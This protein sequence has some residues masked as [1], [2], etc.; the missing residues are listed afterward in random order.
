MTCPT[1]FDHRG[2]VSES[3][4]RLRTRLSGAKVD[5]PEFS[6]YF[7]RYL[8]SYLP[9]LDIMLFRYADIV[10]AALSTHA[11]IR[12]CT[13][14]DFGG[15]TGLL[16]LLA[17]ESGVGRVF[18][19]DIFEG[20]CREARL[21]A[22]QLGLEAD[23]YVCGEIAAIHAELDR[24][25]RGAVALASYDVIEHVYRLTEALA[26]FARLPAENLS[27]FL[28]S[29]ANAANLM[30]RAKLVRHHNLL[31]SHT[32]EHQWGDKPRD[33]NVAYA[34]LRRRI[35]MQAFPSLDSAHL[36]QAVAVTRGMSG[37][38][39]LHTAR[40]FVE[41]GQRPALDKFPSNTCD[42]LTGNWAEHLLDQEALLRDALSC[43]F[44]WAAI[45]PGRYAPYPGRFKRTVGRI[46]NLGVRA[47][48][49][50]LGVCIAPFFAL[51]AV[52]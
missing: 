48:P 20:S 3:V 10:T 36:E 17:R 27:V 28:A 50:N 52:R 32:R 8:R 13:V 33:T 46:L 47:L 40:G 6:A 11:N 25:P 22:K 31:D 51:H 2:P 38:D 16:S 14:V 43:G 23:A 9:I 44:S 12:N 29:S 15:G 49:P 18:Y 19:T 41:S 21:L 1:S 45:V 37:E 7:V 24:G 35:V 5:E 34:E 26:Q 39:L 30:T 4:K 42:P